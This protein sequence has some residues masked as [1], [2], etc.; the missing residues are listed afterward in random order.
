MAILPILTWIG[1]AAA[2]LLGK[3]GDVAR[4]ARQ[5]GCSRQAAYQHADKVLRA[6]GRA[7]DGVTTPEPPRPDPAGQPG[8]QPVPFDK[9]RQQRFA[10]T[11]AAMGLSTAQARE[12]LGI[13]LGRRP[14]ARA[15]VGRWVAQ[16][17]GRATAVLAPLDERARPHAATLALDEIF[18]RGKPVLVAVEPA[19]MAVLHCRRQADRSGPTWEKALTPFDDHLQA[20]VR[21]GGTGMAAAVTALN[22]QRRRQGRPPIDDGL[23]LFHT[24]REARRL[25]GRLWRQVEE[26]WHAAEEADRLRLR[27]AA[28]GRDGRGPAAR[29]RAAWARAFER[30]RW[31]EHWEGLWRRAR[32]ALAVFRPDGRLNDRAAAEAELAAVCHELRAPYWKKLR[33]VLQDSRS[34]TFLDRLA[35]QLA[36]AEPDAALRSELVELWRLDHQPAGGS[37]GVLLPSM[38]ALVCAGWGPGWSESYRRVSAA[39][40]GVVRASSAVECVNSVLRMHQG[41]HRKMTQGL[42]D[43]KRLYWNSRAFRSGKRKGRCPYQLLGLS[44]PTSDF[45]ELLHADTTSLAQDSSTTTV[46]A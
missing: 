30:F 46:A 26:R 44:L 3:H 8:A 23:D 4:A 18:F 35:G 42:L 29:A 39:L 7:R 38:Q 40:S 33:A 43:L 27:A 20:V 1:N 31:Y 24:E 34:L 15:T 22:G 10:A 45:W 32:A 13:A 16:A 9:P 11:A 25:L 6:V 41:R 21:D 14:P 19:S 37:A 2:V 12:L 36:A 28:R 5:A 17:A